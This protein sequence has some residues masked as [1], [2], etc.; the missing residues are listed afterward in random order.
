MR[1]G[2]SP[3]PD[4]AFMFYGIA[5]GR[6]GSESIEFVHVIEDIESLNRKAR[7]GELET[8]A[9]SA[10]A[11][12]YV[13]DKYR[14]L[15]CGAS[16]GE[17]YGPLVV[18][19]DPGLQISRKTI[20]VPGRLTTAFLLLRLYTE[21]FTAVEVPF[22]KIM[23]AVE[24]GD[25]DAGLLIHEGQLTYGDRGLHCV[26]DL[27]RLW[28]EET[29]LPLPLGINVIRRDIDEGLQREVLRVHR[30]SIDYA[31]SHREEA[32]DY[33]LRFGRGL[34]PGLG[35]RFVLMYVNEFTRGLGSRGKAAL[36]F[37]FDRAFKKGVVETPPR[38][39]VL[40]S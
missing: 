10:H 13:Q 7:G 9:L 5:S 22:D 38:L 1:L 19:R 4:D 32:L 23:D 15:S 16:M 36:E 27:A 18:A 12:L 30:E 14:I 40:G 3:D 29:S 33:A 34:A 28:A 20:A 8:T 24:G 26:L 2:H 39:D 37:L 35:E 21:G 25:A 11:Y 31:L 6:V 17:G